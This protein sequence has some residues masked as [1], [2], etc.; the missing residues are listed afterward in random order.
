MDWTQGKEP[1]QCQEEDLS[2]FCHEQCVQDHPSVTL[3][4]SSQLTWVCVFWWSFTPPTCGMA[5]T[6][7]GIETL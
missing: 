2:C 7:G 4:I 1:P 6:S 3:G 5:F